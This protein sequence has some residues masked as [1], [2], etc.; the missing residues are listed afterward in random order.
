MSN[1][2][3]NLTPYRNNIMIMNIGVI[4]LFFIY[5]FRDIVTAKRPLNSAL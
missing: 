3:D 5:I 4:S 2:L 1:D